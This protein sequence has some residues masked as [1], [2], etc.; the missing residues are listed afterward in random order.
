MRCKPHQLGAGILGLTLALFAMNLLGGPRPAPHGLDTLTVIRTII[1]IP[2]ALFSPGLFFA[3]LL[4][5]KS[6][7][8]RSHTKALDLG[9]T[10]IAAAGL[11][12]PFH[13]LVIRLLS[14]SGGAEILSFGGL[15]L[16]LALLGFV[17]GRRL[18]PDIEFAPTSAPVGRAMLL[19]LAVIGAVMLLL[20]PKLVRD[21]SWYFYDAKLDRF[22]NASDEP[23]K[24]KISW[25]DGVPWKNG[26][27]FPRRGRIMRFQ[28]ENNSS[29]DQRVPVVLLVHAPVGTEA[30]VQRLAPAERIFP[31]SSIPTS[32]RMEEGG[33]QIER[34]YRWGTAALPVL[35]CRDDPENP[36]YDPNEICEGTMIPAGGVAIFELHIRPLESVW[37]SD[38]EDTYVVGWAGL[39]TYEFQDALG[40]LG[41]HHMH[42]FQLL[43][44]TEN[45]RW[46]EEVSRGQHVLPGRPARDGEGAQSVAIAQPP[47]WS[48]LLGATRRLAG[49]HSAVASGLLIGLLLLSVLVGL[50]AIDDDGE[51]VLQRPAG[52]I[53]GFAAVQWGQLMINDGSL[54]FPDSLYALALLVSVAS[55]AGRRTGIFVLWATLA[56]LLRY[57]GAVVV[58]MAGAILFVL[59]PKQ[60]RN[61]VDALARFTLILAGFCCLM[62]IAGARSGQLDE[63][64]YSLYWETIP[65]HF[66]NNANAAP[67]GLRPIIFNLKWLAVGG[68]VLFLGIPFRGT[69]S[70]LAAG[71]ALAYMPFLA[72]IDHQSNHYFLPLILLAAL[73]STASVL[74]AEPRRRPTLVVTLAILSGLLYLSSHR[75]RAAVEGWSEK[76][77]VP[78]ETIPLGPDEDAATPPEDAPEES[79]E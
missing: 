65:E 50:K 75:S 55:L 68:A 71:T 44:V 77:S 54:N 32:E 24:L 35:D 2:V 8:S 72:F 53:F 38:E 57:P 9:W 42:P 49:E 4:L 74:R 70:K 40:L 78:H 14:F 56:T 48:Y 31:R 27:Q 5:G 36:P 33:Q 67:L 63:W 1:G 62:L 64:F 34:Y 26:A 47:A 41:H 18:L 11:S 66:Q 30:W 7:R 51:A 39:G 13:F 10:L 6:L 58:G 61:T 46:A 79:L 20:G 29:I 28:V 16:A 21:S 69:L 43:N 19:G 12:L 37:G 22:W 60:R 59:A 73:A 23:E 25:A 52:L 17:L 3:P 76:I 45:I 15:S